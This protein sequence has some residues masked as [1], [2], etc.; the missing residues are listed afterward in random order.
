VS[1]GNHA[2]TFALYRE[3]DKQ[4]LADAALRI[5]NSLFETDPASAMDYFQ[6]AITA[7]LDSVRVRAIGELFE[8]W[9]APPDS[10]G[11][12]SCLSGGAPFDRVAHVIG[13]LRPGES[14]TEYL[15]LLVSSLR[16]QGIASTVFTT[17][18][19]A[20]W[21]F[22]EDVARLSERVDIEADVK[23]ASAQGDFLRRAEGI[24]G[25]LRASGIPVAFFHASLA[26]QIT[27]RV[28]SMRVV[29]VQV[30]VNHG[31]EMDADLFD[32]RIH[33]FENGRRRTRF[34]CRSEWIPPASDIQDRLKVTVP[35]TLHAM[36]LDSASSISATFG[37]LDWNSHSV[38]VRMVGEILNR[39]P[40]HVHLFGG[41]GNVK[42][43]RSYLHGEGVLPRVRFLGDVR[44][45]APLVSL[46]DVYLAP[47]PCAGD[48][49]VL[50]VMG[51]GKPVVVLKFSPDSNYNSAAELVGIPELTAASEGSYIDIADRL[52]RNPEFRRSQGQAVAERFQAEFLPVHLGERYTDFV[53]RL[54][55]VLAPLRGAV[56]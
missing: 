25:E 20:S 45:V 49:A 43:I 16:K 54:V 30:N 12:A 37:N 11:D 24:A 47:F 56:L 1:N 6:R 19:A 3:G 2:Y 27:A 26:E 53:E 31:M 40:D 15:R 55:R 36:G 42:A 41:T 34:T 10:G 22:N 39:F 48:R 5:A 46:M 13:C 21:F 23:I 44:D 29:P 14:S 35:V 50:D 52:L 9:S 17:E 28:A 7:G 51:A 32:G 8:E 38:Y 4:R 33:L 18:W